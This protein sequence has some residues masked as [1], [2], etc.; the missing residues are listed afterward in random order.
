MVDDDKIEEGELNEDTEHEEIDIPE[1]EIPEEGE[2]EEDKVD[3]TSV[4]SSSFSDDIG[5]DEEDPHEAAFNSAKSVDES[6]LD[7]YGVGAPSGFGD[8]E[9]EDYFGDDEEELSDDSN[10]F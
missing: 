3:L 8:D 5:E 4:A 9:E 7:P 1:G 10:A 6:Q 2:L